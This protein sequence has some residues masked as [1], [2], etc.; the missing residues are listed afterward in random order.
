MRHFFAAI[1]VLLGGLFTG[2][3]LADPVTWQVH[4]QRVDVAKYIDYLVEPAE[5][6]PFDELERLPEERWAANPSDSVSFGY[7]GEA[8]WFRLAISPQGGT[9]VPAFLEISY[10]VLDQVDVYIAEKGED[11]RHLRL[12]DKQPFYARPVHHRNFLIPLE[13]R[14]GTLQTV[15]LRVATSSSMQVPLTLWSEEAFYATDQSANIFEGIYYGIILVMILY[16]L[17]V[18]MAVGERSFLY[19]VGYITAMPMFLASLTGMSFQYLWPEAV[20]WNDQAIIVFLSLVMIF[21][22]VFTMRFLSV[23][24]RNHPRLSKVTLTGIAG[25]TCLTLA[26]LFLPYNLLIVP[27]ITLAFLVCTL[28]L[29]LGAYRWYH[30]DPAARYYTV[31]WVFMLFG[32]IVLA[33]SKFTVLPR[34][35]LTENATQIGSALGVIL[36]SIALADRINKE[37]RAAFQAQ[38]RLLREER[39]VRMAQEKSLQVQQEAN[40]QLEARVQERTRDLERL[41]SQLLE[42]NAT[43]GLTGLKNRAH[44]D[45][46]FQSACVKAYR[47]NQPVSLLVIDIDYFKQFNDTYGH[48]VGDDC[49]QMVTQQIR[50]F[51]TRPQDLAAR[52]GGEEFVV[53]LPDTPEDGAL[54]VA[55]KIRREIEQVRFRVSE[56]IIRLTVSIGVATL[57]PT[58][59]DQT[60]VLFEQADA[61]LYQAKH[62]GRNRVIAQHSLNADDEVTLPG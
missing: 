22:S 29:F 47:F 51:V 44:F 14:P 52:Y 45:T 8:Y 2:S 21:G 53:L 33:L 55:E 59:A 60:K 18:Y 13:L 28:V 5:G 30:G 11:I 9:P 58:Q 49:L 48:L 20:W 54:Q 38:Q 34:N 3:V 31:A 37:K 56:D 36:L 50:Q 62:Q 39:K 6:M 32:G 12:G 16:N 24:P 17:F 40:A 26:G 61:A 35:F 27:T 4:S 15:Y 57:V 42:L 10:P 19:Y 1:C 23:V 25:A 41:N 7:R 46:A 43:D